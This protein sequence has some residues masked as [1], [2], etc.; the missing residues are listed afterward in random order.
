[1]WTDRDKLGL[2]LPEQ[3]CNGVLLWVNTTALPSFTFSN[4]SR[5]GG[6]HVVFLVFSFQG[7][8]KSIWSWY[9][10]TLQS[11]I[12]LSKQ[13]SHKD[14]SCRY[15]SSPSA[16]I[17]RFLLCEGEPDIVVLLLLGP[18]ENTRLCGCSSQCNDIP[19]RPGHAH[20]I[21]ASSRLWLLR[22]E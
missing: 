14:N 5:K 13:L 7:Y 12:L 3:Q 17:W 11:A 9:Y 8:S 21:I 4:S 1:M 2:L 19:R 22:L 6:N 15:A 16:S 10:N 20:C 18:G